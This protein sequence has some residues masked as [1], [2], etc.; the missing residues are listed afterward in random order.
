MNLHNL[1]LFII[2]ASLVGFSIYL[3]TLPSI[4]NITNEMKTDTEAIVLITYNLDT[5]AKMID[6]IPP[7]EARKK[8]TSIG[9]YGLRVSQMYGGRGGY[10]CWTEDDIRKMGEGNE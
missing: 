8:C 3:V 6:Y 9:N 4:A 5:D 1:I 7:P 10:A 2:V